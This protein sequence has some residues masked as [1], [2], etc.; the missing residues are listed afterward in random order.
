M[1]PGRAG[2]FIVRRLV[3][4]QPIPVLHCLNIEFEEGAE[5]ER[6]DTLLFEFVRLLFRLRAKT[7]AFEP[8]FQFM[9]PIT[10]SK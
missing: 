3:P 10:H 5:S 4:G 2:L 9:H 1:L 8:L 6:P 7:P